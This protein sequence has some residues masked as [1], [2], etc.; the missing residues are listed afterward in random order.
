MLL[1]FFAVSVNAVDVYK[2]KDKEGNLVFSQTRCVDT[3]SERVD[4]QPASGYDDPYKVKSSMSERA[5][6][7]DKS[8]GKT[9]PKKKRSLDPVAKAKKRCNRYKNAIASVKAKLKKGNSKVEEE[10]LQK[11]MQRYKGYVDKYCV[12]R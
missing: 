11:K 10:R 6:F 9:L 2:C 7:V 5:R 4:V 12:G 3:V 8:D 1:F